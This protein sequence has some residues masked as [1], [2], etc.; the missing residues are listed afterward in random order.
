MKTQAR[1]RLFPHGAQ[2]LFSFF[3]IAFNIAPCS[4]IVGSIAPGGHTLVLFHPESSSA[5]RS[6][7]IGEN[8]PRA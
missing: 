7:A 5:D 8:K 4:L 1:R 3:A 6:P 2:T